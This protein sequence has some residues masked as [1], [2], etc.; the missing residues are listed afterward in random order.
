MNLK[1]ALFT[2]TGLTYKDKACPREASI[3]YKNVDNKQF[4]AL[5]TVILRSQS[6]A[7]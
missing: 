1:D 3:L 5:S 6:L 2:R 7:N 4:F